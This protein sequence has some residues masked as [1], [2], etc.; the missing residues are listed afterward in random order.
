M[1]Q[2]PL[3]ETVAII[4]GK[5]QNI[6]YHQQRMNNAFIYY[7]KHE[8]SFEL[9]DIIKVPEAYQKGLVRCRIDYNTKE[10][11]VQFFHYIPKAIKNFQCVYVENF[12][13]QFKY[14]DRVELDKLKQTAG[15]EIIL[16]NNGFISDCSIGNLLFLK[17]G[18]WYSPNHYLLKGTQLSYLLDEQKISLI[19]IP[20]EALFDYEQIMVINALNPFDLQRAVPITSDRIFR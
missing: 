7:F 10:Y 19:D 16:V 14:T 6:F 15:D 18:K 13:Y 12:D 3:F 2:Y 1:C 20:V 11:Q 17:Q 4:D 9:L 8:N 5:I